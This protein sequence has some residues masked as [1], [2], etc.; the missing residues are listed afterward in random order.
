MI[1][2]RHLRAFVAVA[3]HLHFTKAA[4]AVYLT[5]PALSTLIR[6]LESDL[7]VRLVDRNTRV[8]ELTAAGRD[9][10]ETARRVLTELDTAVA[11]LKPG[12][13]PTRGRV[14]IAALPSISTYVLP[15][16]LRKFKTAHP[17]TDLE[18]HDL[19][20][21]DVITA[22]RSRAVDIGVGYAQTLDDVTARPLFRDKLVLFCSVES[23]LAARSVVR[24]RDLEG[25][26]IIALAK[27]TTARMLVEGTMIKKGIKLNIVMEPR[28]YTVAL[29]LAN[30]GLGAAIVPSVGLPSALPESL[31]YRELIEPVVRRD[32]SLL[33]LRQ[34]RLSPAAKALYDALCAAK[35]EG[36]E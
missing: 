9:F 26:P 28:L 33:T 6:Q 18:F 20:G 34:Y 7:G 13:Q 31:A 24:W 15:G 3:E 16:V 30:A 23:R 19:S 27:G 12:K 21:E 2:L 32:I 14:A 5:Q 25:E 35:Y 36:Y 8:T 11:G 22:L 10:Y 1:N 29:A 4:E 17:E